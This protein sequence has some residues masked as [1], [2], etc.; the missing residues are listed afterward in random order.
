ME[1]VQP[2]L[3]KISL[4][5]QASCIV[6]REYL[7]SGEEEKLEAAQL[8]LLQK[9]KNYSLGPEDQANLRYLLENFQET[10]KEIQAIGEK[11]FEDYPIN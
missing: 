7:E 6:I 3:E 1:E 9:E 8:Y 4:H 10:N 2:L 11:Y 5:K